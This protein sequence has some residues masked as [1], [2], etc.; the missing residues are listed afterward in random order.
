MAAWGPATIDGKLYH[1]RSMDW[2]VT[3][4][5]DPETGKFVFDNQIL[6]LRKPEGG[7]ASLSPTIAGQLACDGGIN[8]KGI[9][10]STKLSWIKEDISNYACP[11]GVRQKMALDQASTIEDV[12][13]IINSSRTRG[14]NFIV[15]DGKI[16][17]GYAVEQTANVSYIGSWDDPVESTKPFWSIDHV[18]RRGNLFINPECAAVQRTHYYPWSFIRYFIFGYL[19]R[20]LGFYKFENYYFY[21]Q[22]MRYKGLSIGIEEIWGTMDLNTTMSML[23]SV[24]RGETLDVMDFKK[25]FIFATNTAYQWVAC[26]ETGDIVISFSSGE[27]NAHEN[28]VHYFNLFDL[29]EQ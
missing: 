20:I 8:E 19:A 25:Q 9:A 4:I 10:S 29:L 2:F 1:L 27:T 14:W 21:P 28:P 23:R 24:Y 16:P 6:L 18:V 13:T 15:S 22:W 5:I 17:V 26:P 3:Q 7:Y 12:I 11:M